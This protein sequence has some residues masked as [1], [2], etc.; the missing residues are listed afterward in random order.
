MATP[1]M[2]Q[3]PDGRETRVSP[4]KLEVRALEA[5]DDGSR[6]VKG[7]AVVFDSPTN[8][9]GYFIETIAKGA[10]T[11]TLRSAD[12]I[13]LYHHDRARVIGRSSIGTLRLAEDD[14]GLSVEIDLP[15]TT[16]GQDLYV[17]IKR[18]DVSGMSFGFCT[19]KEEWD[20]TG[21]LPKRTVLQVELYEVT[22]TAFP[23]Y[24]DT[25]I[26]MRSLE[27]ARAERR[28][29]NKVAASIRISQRRARQAQAERNIH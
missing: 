21:D 7:Y 14:R 1:A 18:G 20:E 28:E 4:L 6:T 9:G 15:E 17:L 29:H 22:V 27:S 16:D 13:A 5:G 23:A 19:T 10:F 25:E 26:A 2:P 24:S 3:T 11:E 8:I 12:V